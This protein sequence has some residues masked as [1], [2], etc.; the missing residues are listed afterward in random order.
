MNSLMTL[1]EYIEKL[2][3]WDSDES[4]L[5]DATILASLKILKKCHEEI[6]NNNSYLIAPLLRQ[7]Q[8]N[9]IVVAGLSEG[10][11]TAEK[12]VKEK[13]NPKNIMNAI[14]EKGLEIKESEFDWF[15]EYLI[16][17]KEKLNDYSHTNFDGIMSLF[18]ER[19]Q[20]FEAQQFNK[21]M[22]GLMIQ[23]IE[24]PFIIMVNYIYSLNVELPKIK[25]Y[26]KELKE[27][28]TLKYA[29]RNFPEPIKVFIKQSEFIQDYYTNAVNDLKKT[30]KEYKEIK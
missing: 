30:L 9:F 22:A 5:I 24:C 29:T 1:I 15:N 23:F 8:E 28:G 18:T 12:Y 26:Y 21:I 16:K 11:L 6:E 7:V 3:T 2:E 10:V 4:F 27:F 25:N 19:F 17:I 20:V 13:H 14:K